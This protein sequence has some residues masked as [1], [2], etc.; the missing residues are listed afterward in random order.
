MTSYTASCHCGAVV[1]E[2]RRKPRQLNTV[3]LLDIPAVRCPL[4]IFPAEDHSRAGY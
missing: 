3:Q 2:M 4:G 1:L